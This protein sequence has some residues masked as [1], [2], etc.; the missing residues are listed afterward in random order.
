MSTG[1]VNTVGGSPI[2]VS[3]LASGLDTSSIIQAL[4]AAERQ[5]IAHLTNQQEKLSGQQ[6]QLQGLK[7]SL[8]HL[9]FAADEFILPS[10]FEGVQ[11]ISSSEPARV[12]A[13][14]TG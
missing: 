3:G 12:S 4:L 9:S 11:T 1:S 5:P 10:L 2:S 8:L 6:A 7:T 14:I 13:T